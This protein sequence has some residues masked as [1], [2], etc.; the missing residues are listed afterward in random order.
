M[1]KGLCLMNGIVE[2]H[3]KDLGV[4]KG[5]PLQGM[6]AAMTVDGGLFTFRGPVVMGNRQLFYAFPVQESM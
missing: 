6:Q 1:N 5:Y 2:L 4:L 3:I